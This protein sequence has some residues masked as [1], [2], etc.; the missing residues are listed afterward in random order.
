MKVQDILTGPEKWVKGNYAVDKYGSSVSCNDKNADAFCLVGAINLCYYNDNID[1]YIKI[2]KTVVDEIYKIK[3]M[4]NSTDI[5]LTNIVNFNDDPGT[6]FE[7]I[8][9]LIKKS[10]I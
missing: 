9:K 10:D 2:V 3:G 7:D 8:D 1:I 4:E 5:D 6:T